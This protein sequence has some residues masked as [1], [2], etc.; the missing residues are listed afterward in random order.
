MLK[1]VKKLFRQYLLPLVSRGAPGKTQSPPRQP[2]LD[3]KQL[4]FTKNEL[5]R[6]TLPTGFNPTIS[7][8]MPTYN[9]GELISKAIKSV[10]SQTYRNFQL[11]IVDDGSKDNTRSIVE[12]FEDPRILYIY[13][14][15]QGVSAARNTGLRAAT[16][17]YV[18]YIDSDNQWRDKYL[19]YSVKFS[20]K[21]DADCIYSILT[22]VDGKG[23]VKA[24]RAGKFD[25]AALWDRN[26]ID[27]NVFFHRLYSDKQVEFDNRLRRAV[28]WDYIVRVSNIYG[29]KFAY[30]DQCAYSDAEDSSRLTL[31]AFSLYTKVVRAKNYFYAKDEIELLRLARLA[32]AIVISAPSAERANW[33]DYY[34]AR[35]L[36]KYLVKLG[37]AADLVYSDT[38]DAAKQKFDVN[39][40]IRGRRREKHKGHQLN[41]L[42]IISHPETVT[43]EECLEYNYVFAASAYLEAL[44]RIEGVKKV[45]TLLQA[46]DPEL[47]HKSPGTARSGILFVGRTKNVDR[48]FVVDIVQSMQDA[49]VIGDGWE[50]YIDQTK[51]QAQWVQYPEL[52]RVYRAANIV[53]AEHW[54]SMRLFGIVANRVSDAIGS[55]ARVLSDK[56]RGDEYLAGTGYRSCANPKEAV[57]ILDQW[58]SELSVPDVRGFVSMEAQA[59]S[60][61]SVIASLVFRFQEKTSVDD[62]Q[63]TLVIK[64]GSDWLSVEWLFIN[65]I[66]PQIPANKLVRLGVRYESVDGE[67]L[68]EINGHQASVSKLPAIL[69]GQPENIFRNWEGLDERLWRIFSVGKHKTCNPRIGTLITNSVEEA[70][71]E[72]GEFINAFDQV[73]I[74]DPYLT[75][76]TVVRNGKLHKE[77]QFQES[78]RS[79]IRRYLLDA[80]SLVTALG[81]SVTGQEFYYHVGLAAGSYVLP[82]AP[83]SADSIRAKEKWRGFFIDRSSNLQEL[84]T[85]FVAEKLR[86]Q[87]WAQFADHEMK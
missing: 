52:P 58:K 76:R 36:Q 22:I 84:P 56:V 68:F 21:H 11:I 14:E 1:P 54:R 72:Y 48:R 24:Y 4:R 44:L 37:Y 10:L 71:A 2:K 51:I 61:D 64:Q 65:Y 7:I 57:K 32:V 67:S 5:E 12:S 35:A 55:G 41:I 50:K 28:D 39:I 26:F 19:E 29:C 16:G 46:S 20:K 82:S 59:R 78:A 66:I 47:F 25:A 49:R 86:Q 31:S 33:G 75:R 30:F 81:S 79:R 63:D 3:S 23:A 34:Y 45:S 42:W 38:P 87:Y 53:L 43:A 40:V 15:N 73:R 9:R 60:I 18:A 83:V 8:I 13:Q 85:D 17:E 27:L 80:E 6:F 77:A 74:W 70:F 62:S 69:L